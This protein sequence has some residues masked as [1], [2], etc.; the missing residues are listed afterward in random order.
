[1][2]QVV[3][4]ERPVTVLDPPAPPHPRPT[5][6]PELE[7]EAPEGS[8]PAADAP[9][10]SPRA[11]FQLRCERLARRLAASTFE[12]RIDIYTDKEERVTYRELSTAAALCPELMPV[13]NGEFE[14]IALTSA[15][16]D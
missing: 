2:S 8:G 11:A 5:P 15:D 12:E 7:P 6:P 4:I 3:L 10:L 1:M 14:W 9:E 13:I 16:L